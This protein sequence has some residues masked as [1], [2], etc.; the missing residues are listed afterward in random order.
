M[1]IENIIIMDS[2]NG[3]VITGRFVQKSEISI[4]DARLV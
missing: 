2:V 3:K 1:S 4:V